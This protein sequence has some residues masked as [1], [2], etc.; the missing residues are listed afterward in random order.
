MIKTSTILLDN[1]VRLVLS[2]DKS[3]NQTYAELIVKYGGMF[4]NFKVNNKKYTIPEGFAH[5]LEHTIVENN[6]Y[7][8]MFDYLKD[9]HVTFNARTTINKTCFFIDTVF[10]FYTHLEELIKIVNIPVFTE[11]K[12]NDIKKPIIEEIKRGKDRAYKKFDKKVNECSYKNIKFGDCLGSTEDI[13]N[14]KY[15]FVKLVYDVFYQPENQ[16]IFITGNFDEKKVKEVVEKTYKEINKKKIEYQLLDKKEVVK[17]NKKH[18]TVIDNMYN[19]L[20]N[21]TFKVDIST[22]TPKERVKGTFYLNHFLSYN[23]N[24]SS[25]AFKEIIDKK[26]SVYSIDRNTSEYIK[27]MY[28]IDL[29]M[30][31]TNEKEFKRIVFD[32]LKNKYYDE[33]MFYLWKKQCLVDMIIRD[34]YPHKTGLTFLDNILYFD[35]YERDKISDVE[36]FSLE[37]YKEFL[38]KLNFDNYCIVCQKKGSK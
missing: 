38:N 1:G 7:G 10:D 18:G 21:I 29:G 11:E 19:E 4:K 22:L 37:D 20:I 12:L 9:K 35:Y 6:V 13:N 16:I 14:I 24:D 5:L 28:I 34:S 36:E 30:Y 27:D 3:K 32:V 25:K 8:N 26:Y 23:F 31:G 15:D 17:V 33:E 2:Q